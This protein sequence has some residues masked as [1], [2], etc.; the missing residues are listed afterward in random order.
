MFEEQSKHQHT[1][2]SDS[3]LYV[4][5]VDSVNDVCLDGVLVPRGSRVGFEVKNRPLSRSLSLPISLS[6]YLTL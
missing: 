6:H 5:D 1:L 4:T 2:D 3:V